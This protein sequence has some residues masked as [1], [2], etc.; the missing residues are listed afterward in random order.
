MVCKVT[1]LHF[2]VGRERNGKIWNNARRRDKIA[3]V[4]PCNTFPPVGPPETIADSLVEL[5]L[6]YLT[7]SNGAA[8][9]IHT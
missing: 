4:E 3:L 2:I 9:P 8:M 6:C 5:P 1:D 7:A